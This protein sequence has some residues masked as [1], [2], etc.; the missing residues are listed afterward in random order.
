MLSPF[1]SSGVDLR[2][3]ALYAEA[4]GRGAVVRNLLLIKGSD[5]TWK[6]DAQGGGLTRIVLVAMATGSGDQP[7]ASMGR[8][9]DVRIPP[10]KMGEAMRDGALYTLD[11]PVPKRGAYQIRVAVKDQ[12]TGKTGSATQFLQIPDMK[13]T[14]FALSSV[15]LRDSLPSPDKPAMPEIA[16]ALRKFPRGGS[17]EFLCAVRQGHKKNVALETRVRLLRDGKEVYAA[18]VSMGELKGV[19]PVIFG[20]L[21]LGGVTPGDYD[22][23]VIAT[24]RN[25]GKG[26]AAG[27][28]T[29]FTVLP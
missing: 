2:L 12:A 16:A 17:I 11:V 19:G 6:L 25:G 4:P 23:Q 9:Y 29:N 27:Q 21:N 24:D 8:V 20:G 26:A 28:W 13:R 18:P 7:L 10:E 22:L 14:G 1:K 5:L 15:F 3:T